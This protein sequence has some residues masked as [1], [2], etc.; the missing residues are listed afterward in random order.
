MTTRTS[1]PPPDRSES[2][3]RSVRNYLLDARFQL[4]YAGF[5]VAV[6]V[7]ISGVTG[8]VL[9][10]T[11]RAVVAESAALIDESKKVS[12]VSRMNIRDL[13][14]DSPELLSEFDKE[15]EVHDKAIAGEQ[16]LLIQRQRWMISSLVGGLALMVALLGVLGIYFTHKVIGPVFKM[17]RLLS[18]VGEGKLGIDSRLRKG[19]ELQEFFETF[20]LMV[21]GLRKVQ[22]RHIV[23]VEEAI[24]ALDRD[25]KSDAAKSLADVRDDMKRALAKS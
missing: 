13:A 24:A 15:A 9:Y 10:Q 20:R 5:L 4:K 21:A 2:Y 18:K 6:A 3:K 16:S 22:E 14:G 12:E 25:A 23:Q 19:D 17:K 1:A 11:T 8:A 7:A